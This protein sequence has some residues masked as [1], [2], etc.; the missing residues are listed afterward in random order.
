MTTNATCS[1]MSTALSPIRSRARATSIMSSPTRACRRPSPISIAQLEDLAVE[2]VDLLV[3]AHEVLGQRRRRAARTPAWPAR[4]RSARARPMRIDPL[5]R[6]P[7]APAARARTAGCILAMFTHWS[8][9]RST[10][11]ITCSSAATSPQVAGHR[12]LQREQ[13]EDALVDLQVAPVEPVVVEDHDRG[14][15]DVLV[16]SASIARSSALTTRSSPPS[17]CASSACSSSL[18][19]LAGLAAPSAEL[20]R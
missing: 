7:R 20:A 12:R 3:L 11:L 19:V 1:P 6:S 4:P 2:A 14:E 10:C 13:R 15:L 16:L 9:M 18:E 8:P 17:A 5:E